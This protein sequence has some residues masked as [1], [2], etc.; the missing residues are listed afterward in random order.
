[1]TT[2]YLVRTEPGRLATKV[3]QIHFYAV[4]IAMEKDFECSPSKIISLEDA[5]VI[6]IGLAQGKDKGAIG[7]Y[8]W[9]MEG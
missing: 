8:G 9:L 2:V 4:S 7:R 3:G 6:A 1:V 5:K